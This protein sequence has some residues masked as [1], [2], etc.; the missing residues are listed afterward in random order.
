MQ[1]NPENLIEDL[2]HS[3][4]TE[5]NLCL[6]E[7]TRDKNDTE[8]ISGLLEIADRLSS[9]N[10]LTSPSPNKQW[11][12]INTLGTHN[13]QGLTRQKL[14]KIFAWPASLALIL[15]VSIQTF[16]KSQ[17]SLPGSTF[18]PI[19]KLGEQA[20]VYTVVKNPQAFAEAQLNITEKRLIETQNI[21]NNDDFNEAIKSKALEELKDQAK[22]TL[23]LFKEV[24]VG[25]SRDTKFVKDLENLNKKLVALKEST[26]E[27][28][29]HAI[30]SEVA[31][32]SQKTTDE[33][34]SIIAATPDETSLTLENS[35]NVQITGKLVT[36]TKEKLVVEK[37]T[38]TYKQSKLIINNV[39]GITSFTN[40]NIGST[41]AVKGIRNSDGILEATEITIQ[42]QAPKESKPVI[43]KPIE[44]TPATPTTNT[45][46]TGLI[47]E[48]PNPTS[49]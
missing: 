15:L 8:D 2:L 41:I 43:E 10:F 16:E 47:I 44:E 3:S 37:T 12:Y 42:K 20:K 32:E 40:L 6:A 28:K 17:E 39:S 22:A 19:K 25:K 27:E 34:L 18:F 35:N 24:A 1:K 21:L 4:K 26:K 30:A 36:L 14:I 23:P 48:S 7:E 38:F 49:K 9:V 29:N 45:L 13:P 31:K 11:K 46:Q 33:V 5:R